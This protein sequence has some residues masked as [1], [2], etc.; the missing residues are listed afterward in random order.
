MDS[1]CRVSDPLGAP[2]AMITRYYET[3][4]GLSSVRNRIHDEEEELIELTKVLYLEREKLLL[5]A[6]SRTNEL[7][8]F[9]L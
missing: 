1:A 5:V 7:Q 4:S 3:Y 8:V 6:D 9:S 2:L